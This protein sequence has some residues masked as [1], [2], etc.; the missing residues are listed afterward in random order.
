MDQVAT[1]FDADG[2]IVVGQDGSP[3]SSA[4]VRWAVHTADRLGCTVHVV[5]TWS[6]SSAPRP[7]SWAPGYV[8]PLVDFEAAVLGELER[9]VAALDLRSDVPVVCHVLHGSPARRLLESCGRA[10]MLVVGSRGRGGF[11]GLVLGST[12]NQLVGHAAV[13]V[14]VV[15]VTAADAS[16][17][18][19][20]GLRD[21]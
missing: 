4:A 15:P 6:L 17:E 2:G 16:A 20:A 18:P 9:D 10:Q 1:S 21:R 19:D 7:A 12:A 13:P 5:R 8:P 3:Q 11:R 14:V